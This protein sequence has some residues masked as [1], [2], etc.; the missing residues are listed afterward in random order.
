MT[1]LLRRLRYADP[2]TVEEA[3][4]RR[5]RAL[6][7]ATYLPASMWWVYPP[8][9]IAALVALLR[10]TYLDGWRSGYNRGA[11]HGFQKAHEQSARLPLGVSKV[12][13]NRDR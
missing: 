12:W 9:T 2:A 4:H 7:A 10:M 3:N 5:T 8:T 1:T 6:I 13:R 11:V